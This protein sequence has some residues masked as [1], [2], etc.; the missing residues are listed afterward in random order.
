VRLTLASGDAVKKERRF[1]VRLHF[2]EPD[3]LSPGDRV[4]VNKMS[5]RLGDPQRALAASSPGRGCGS[6]LRAHGIAQLLAGCGADAGSTR[7]TW[8]RASRSGKSVGA[9][10]PTSDATRP[11]TTAPLSH[12]SSG[13]C[14][15]PSIR[16]PGASDA[17]R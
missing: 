1:T 2:A 9:C 12:H 5:Y 11:V 10:T 4:F 17:I 15:G 6:S 13:E 8:I 16:S 14:V 7:V 3:N